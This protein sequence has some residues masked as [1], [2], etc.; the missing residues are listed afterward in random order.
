MACSR[1]I[2]LIDIPIVC[3]NSKGF[4]DPFLQM[5]H[6]VYQDQLTKKQPH[7]IIHFVTNG[8]EAVQY[9]EEF[10]V[11]DLEYP[12]TF[13]SMTQDYIHTILAGFQ[14]IRFTSFQKRFKS[15]LPFFIFSLVFNSISLIS[16][17]T[18]YLHHSNS[19]YHLP[20]IIIETFSIGINQ[21]QPSLH[22]NFHFKLHF[23]FH[24]SSSACL[25]HTRKLV[26]SRKH[27]L[28]TM[29]PKIQYIWKNGGLIS[30]INVVRLLEASQKSSRQIH[31]LTVRY[32]FRNMLILKQ[33]QSLPNLK[34]Q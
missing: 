32:I 2:N 7:E 24:L 1:N 16:I 29:I 8:L 28:S 25:V 9:I 10:Y 30:P 15:S 26:L 22:F 11:V 21:L 31:T 3:I 6:R 33:K 5:L 13:T 27:S 19:N 12:I 17:I 18:R 34:K 14:T 20:N 23:N 4:Y